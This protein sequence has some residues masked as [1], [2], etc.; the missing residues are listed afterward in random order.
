MQRSIFILLLAVALGATGCT[1]VTYKSKRNVPISMKADYEANKTIADTITG[2]LD[3]EG[4]KGQ[5]KAKYPDVSDDALDDF[6]IK[7]DSQFIE[8]NLTPIIQAEIIYYDQTFPANEIMDFALT[9]VEAEVA[10]FQ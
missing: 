10:K 9:L 4:I 1:S 5:I 3:V 2:G 8:G 6:T 7:V